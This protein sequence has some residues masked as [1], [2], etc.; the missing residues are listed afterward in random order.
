[1]DKTKINEVLSE[2]L[3]FDQELPTP[4]PVIQIGGKICATAG[5]FICI[6]G[7][8]KSR[9]TT[10]ST[11]MI[12]SAFLKKPVF[13]MVVNLD[14]AD[15]IILI[16]TEQG[17]YDFS[18][19][20]KLLKHTI[21]SKKLPDNFSAYLFRKYDPDV[22]LNSIYTLVNEQKPK[23]LFIDNLT[24]LVINPNDMVESKKVIQFLK[25][26]TGEFNIVI[27]CLLHLS[28][29]NLQTLGN[30][31]SYADRGAQ[32]VI[33][34]SIDKETQISTL[35]PILL[36]SDMYFDPI[37]IL[38]DQDLKEYTQTAHTSE[39]PKS[40]RKFILMDLTDQDHF[41]RLGVVFIDNKKIIYGE[42]VEEIK[43]IYGVG[44]N[45]AKQQIIPYLLGNKYML[46]EKG[47]YEFN[48]YK[49][50]KTK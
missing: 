18:K 24:E 36:R 35:E 28:K 37:S 19:Q 42:L 32:S 5:N 50:V 27:V 11:L 15:K 21:G 9:K 2:A 39:K 46:S 26:L 20:I 48:P 23:I 41:N 49:N 8:P 38:Y 17:V 6:S 10:F 45:I 43:K 1:M 14:P 47:V 31:G 3:Y 22:I 4:P 34:V 40:T 16:D 13:D 7:L 33:K 12:A 25:L 30:L 29:S 44:T